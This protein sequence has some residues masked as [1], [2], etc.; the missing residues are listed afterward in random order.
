ME[1]CQRW[2]QRQS[3]ICMQDVMSAVSHQHS[4]QSVV[5]RTI[6][7]GSHSTHRGCTGLNCF[8][9]LCS[10]RYCFFSRPV[11]CT[12]SLT[13]CNKLKLQISENKC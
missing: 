13:S 4:D 9:G 5:L 8:S 11:G 1:A 10:T 12:Y 6:A 7:E 2:L 3:A